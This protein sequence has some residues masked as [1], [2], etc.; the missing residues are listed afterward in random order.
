MTR[1][2]RTQNT[3]DLLMSP[4]GR[5][6]DAETA[7]VRREMVKRRHLVGSLVSYVVIV[8]IMIA[9]WATSGGGY[10]WPGWIMGIG[11]VALVLRGSGFRDYRRGP[12]ADADVDAELH[13]RRSRK[14]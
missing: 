2:D 7:Q 8:A 3:D 11:A 14:R 12:I 13:R 4:T 9:I 10:F 6:E 5:E 1:H